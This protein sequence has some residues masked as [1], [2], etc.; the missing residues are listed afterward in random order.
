MIRKSYAIAA[1]FVAI[2]AFALLARAA[3][4]SEEMKFNFAGWLETFLPFAVGVALAWLITRENRGW[5]IWLITLVVGLIIWGFYRDK[6]PH[7]SF[8]IV[9]S[10]MS[11][12][13][14][15]GWRGVVALAQKRR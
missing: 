10:S 14:M 6:L 2:A 15:L 8:V 12:L 7:W 11:A 4:Q 5:L 1:D 9:A 3:H 13:L